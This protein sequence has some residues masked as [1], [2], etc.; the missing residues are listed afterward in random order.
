MIGQNYR[1]VVGDDRDPAF[2]RNVYHRSVQVA[3]PA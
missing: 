3:N 2:S 1:M